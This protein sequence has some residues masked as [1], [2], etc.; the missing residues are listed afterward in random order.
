MAGEIVTDNLAMFRILEE[1]LHDPAVRRSADLA[2]ALLDEDFVEFGSSG[3][4]YGRAAILEAL[5][6]E[7]DGADSPVSA[8]DYALTWLSQDVALLTYRSK[9]GARHSLRS[10]I[11][12]HRDGRWQMVFHQGTKTAG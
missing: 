3:T 8:S 10:S 1:R 11:W 2:G 5:G 4:I 12:R 9:R 7:T 6:Q